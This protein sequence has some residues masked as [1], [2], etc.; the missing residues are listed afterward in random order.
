MAKQ[1]DI[2]KLVE[3]VERLRGEG[4]CP[5]DKEQTRESLKPMLIEEAYEVLEAL[6]GNDPQELKEELG[7][8]LF[9][10][11]FHAQIAKE[12]GEFEL[13]DVVDR[14]HQKMVRRHPHVFGTADLKTSQDVLRNW[15]DIKAS[16]KGHTSTYEPDSRVSLL[17]GIPL[18][19]PALHEAFQL[20]AKASRVGFDW[21]RLEEILRKLQEE[22]DE[23]LRA[24]R[25]GNAQEMAD[26]VGDILF[27]AVNVARFLGID[28]ETALKRCNRKFIKRF[29][30]VE[31][32]IKTQGKDLKDA[33]LAEMD[34]L[35][36]QAKKE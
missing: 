18:K 3:L 5:W 1:T 33:T 27:V 16:E 13:A 14:S 25:T 31:A 11:V 4:G 2:Q 29:Q 6:D 21:G 23:L 12:Q 36:E 32:G 22:S 34:A 17:A 35:W 10:I 9:Q 28:P 24:Q 26:E 20:T 15:E 30:F 7:D 8:L 19:L